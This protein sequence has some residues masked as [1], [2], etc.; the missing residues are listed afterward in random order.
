M[1]TMTRYPLLFEFKDQ[2]AV[3]DHLV[4]VVSKG[5]VLAVQEPKGWWFYGVN[6]GGLAESGGTSAEAFAAFRK[7]FSEVLQDIASSSTDV[8]AFKAEARDFFTSN[9]PVQADWETAVEAVRQGL[10]NLEELPR[11]SADSPVG[12]EVQVVGLSTLTL[13][14]TPMA[15]AA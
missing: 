8:Q 2:L 6:P 14:R 3:R 9:R 13:D 15:L 7:V 10:L 1:D 5:R 12:V 11:K 4:E